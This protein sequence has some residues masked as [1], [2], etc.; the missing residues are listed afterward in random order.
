MKKDKIK[1]LLALLICGLI[2]QSC[3]KEEITQTNSFV[4]TD[5]LGSESPEIVASLSNEIVFRWT[6]LLLE[7]ER[8]AAGMRPNASARALAYIHLAAYET[9]VPGMEGYSSATERLNGVNIRGEEM[10]DQVHWEL[11]LNACY[12]DVLD[13]FLLNLPNLSLIHI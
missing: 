5:E 13:H 3:S 4:N 1:L 8:Y 10:P 11:A 7:L 6:E 2:F 9:V 12:A